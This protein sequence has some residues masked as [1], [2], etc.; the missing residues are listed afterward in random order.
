MPF[1]FGALV[2]GVVTHLIRR[3]RERMV[4]L[5]WSATHQTVAIS[6]TDATFGKVE[7]IHNGNPVQN[8]AMC[9]IDIENESTHDLTDVDFAVS[10]SDG[11]TFLTSVASLRDTVLLAFTPE[12]N[13]SLAA[14]AGPP[15]PPQPTYGRLLEVLTK[16]RAYRIPVLNRGAK[17]D[18]VALVQ[19]PP[20]VAPLA[21][22]TCMHKGV[23]LREQK[24]SPMF[25]GVPQLHATWIGFLLGL[26]AV[27]VLPWDRLTST[28]GTLIAFIMG[29]TV[30][31]IGA[32][33]VRF[34]R[35]V[36]RIV[37]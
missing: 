31:G 30:M 23:R 7:V 20:G 27:F 33:A 25:F 21:A 4:T 16:T 15:T 24:P 13:Q 6:T 1:L 37:G 2:T 35:L 9:F 34:T 32:F 29:A 26:I 28:A 18:F 8:L 3:W 12:W 19:V 22:V 36:A 10:Y 11:T 5:R 14:L 17:A